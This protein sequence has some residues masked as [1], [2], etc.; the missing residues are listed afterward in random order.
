[1]VSI[2]EGA[3]GD[4]AGGTAVEGIVVVVDTVEGIAVEG[5]VVVVDTVEGI[6]VED[7]VVV[8]DTAEDIVEDTA[9]VAV[10]LYQQAFH[11]EL[12]PSHGCEYGLRHVDLFLHAL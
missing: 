1:M 12:Y 4:T 3:A 5:I 9:A 8:G 6:A 10:V 7:I 2:A 11:D